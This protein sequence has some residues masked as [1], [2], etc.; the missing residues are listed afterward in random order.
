MRI[1]TLLL[2]VTLLWGC[3]TNMASYNSVHGDSVV[4]QHQDMCGSDNATELGECQ[5]AQEPA[6]EKTP[7]TDNII[8]QT[9]KVVVGGVLLVALIAVSILAH[10]PA[11]AL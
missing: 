4:A 10:V 1:L 7:P 6:A 8:A 9:V 11:G 2:I 5:T 3:S